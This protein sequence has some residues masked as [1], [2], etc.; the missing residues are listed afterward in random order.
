MKF[1]KTTLAPTIVI[2]LLLFWIT[3]TFAAPNEMN[4]QGRLTDVSSGN[5]LPDGSYLM[6]FW[7]YDAA[8]DGTLLW[9]ETQ[10]VLVTDGIY[11]VTLGQGTP[12]PSFGA[13]NADLFSGDNRWLQVSVNGEYL[14]PRQKITSVA[15]AL[16]AAS[17]V[18]G[19]I[20]TDMIQNGAIDQTKIADGAVLTELLD[21]DG[22]D[23]ELDADMLDGKNSSDFAQSEH[24]HDSRYYTKEE[25]DKK[26]DGYEKRIA[27]LEAKLLSLS[28]S[29]DG[30]DLT[31]SGVDIHIINGTGVTD[32]LNG[33]GNLIVGYGHGKANNASHNIVVGDHNVFRSYGGLIAGTLN[34]IEGPYA[35]VSGG[36]GNVA[37]GLHSSVSG[38]YGN[39]AEG[40]QSNI[41]G[42]RYNW[43]IGKASSISGGGGVYHTEGNL[44][45]GNYSS[46]LGGMANVTGDSSCGIVSDGLGDY[47]VICDTPDPNYTLGANTTVS[48]GRL[49]KASDFVSTVSGGEGNSASNR[50]AAVIGG[51]ANNATGYHST[52]VG[53]QGN[54]NSVG[55][56]TMSGEISVDVLEITGP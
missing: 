17:V 15:Y 43:A 25:V 40:S 27:D 22:S 16:Q 21:D 5:P 29:A 52:I 10:D 48:G 20:V 4:F 51:D 53:G 45:I 24:N 6:E 18:N 50:G 34:K 44:A 3:P 7:L 54:E 1:F 9:G 14:I 46:I 47:E 2:I 31:F 38:G 49:N 56:T 30:K 12:M 8:S 11:N 37:S 23:S 36:L 26:F 13:F 41:S 39:R 28:V 42:G 32:S 19:A 33:T 35:S 55:Y